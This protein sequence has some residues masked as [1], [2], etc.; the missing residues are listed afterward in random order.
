MN[1]SYLTAAEKKEIKELEARYNKLENECLK[2]TISAHKEELNL[3]AMANI[4]TR[5]ARICHNARKRSR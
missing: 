3:N 4:Q 1:Y 2:P 5:I